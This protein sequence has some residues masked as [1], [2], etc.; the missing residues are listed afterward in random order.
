MFLGVKNTKSTRSLAAT[1]RPGQKSRVSL[2]FFAG[3]KEMPNFALPFMLRE[4][5][6]HSH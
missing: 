1:L 6:I 4:E 3:F 5:L 2:G